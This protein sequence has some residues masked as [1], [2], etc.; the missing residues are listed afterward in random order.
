MRQRL[1]G[2]MNHGDHNAAFYDQIYPCLAVAWIFKWALAID[3]AAFRFRVTGSLGHQR[4]LAAMR[5]LE[6]WLANSQEFNQGNG[7]LGLSQAH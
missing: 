6:R 1:I 3:A 5:A 4:W 2:N 7:D